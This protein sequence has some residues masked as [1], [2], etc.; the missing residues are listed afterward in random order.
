MFT[1]LKQVV[2]VHETFFLFE[3]QPYLPM[4][5]WITKISLI[6]L[7]NTVF[8]I[9]C[10]MFTKFIQYVDVHETFFSRKSARSACQ[11][12]SVDHIYLAV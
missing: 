5:D 8:S 1:K 7:M 12:K 4:H 11:C 9:Y 10:L 2:D 6:Q 3:N